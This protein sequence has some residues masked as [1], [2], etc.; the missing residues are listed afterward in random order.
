MTV[1]SDCPRGQSPVPVPSDSPR[2]EPRTPRT[3]SPGKIHQCTAPRPFQSSCPPTTRSAT[4]APAVEDFLSPDVVDEVVVVDN[5]SR[6]RTADEARQTRARLVQETRQGYGF[7]LRRGLQEAT[8]RHRHPGRA[9]RHV[10]RPRRAEA[11]RLC[12]RLRHGLRHQDDARAD[13]GPGEHGLVPANGELGRRQDAAGALRRTV[14]ERLRLH[15]AADAP[16]RARADPRRPDRRR[17][18][19]P[20]RRW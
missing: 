6:D 9:R 13:V 11:A 4:S 18:A 14:A 19:L 17:L 12:R 16:R 20:A 15:A 1:P 10:H 8:R 7:A 5:N 3:P 2:T